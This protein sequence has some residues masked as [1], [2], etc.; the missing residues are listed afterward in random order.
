[1]HTRSKVLG[2]A[3]ECGFEIRLPR[4]GSYEALYTPMN[5]EVVDFAYRP[6]SSLALYGLAVSV[7]RERNSFPF[8]L[9][10]PFGAAKS[11]KTV[12]ARFKSHFK[13]TKDHFAS[14]AAAPSIHFDVTTDAENPRFRLHLPPRSS[15]YSTYPGFWYLLGF[16]EPFKKQDVKIAGRGATGFEVYG[17]FND[18]GDVALNKQGSIFF[19]QVKFEDLLAG[20]PANQAAAPAEVLIQAEIQKKSVKKIV[21][22][23][24]SETDRLTVQKALT[25][26]MSSTLAACNVDASARFKIYQ[27]GADSLKIVTVPNAR[28]TDTAVEVFFNSDLST[29]LQWPKGQSLSFRLAEPLEQAFT[30][31]PQ[32]L[33]GF[34]GKYPVTVLMNGFGEARHWIAGRGYCSVLAVLRENMPP[35]TMPVLFETDQYNLRLE[36]IDYATDTITFPLGEG[37]MDMKMQFTSL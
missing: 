9:M 12:D 31:A 29:V 5:G 8:T 20:L 3:K 36:F 19:P 23:T 27:V 34:K 2:G 37:E 4:F 15:L 6:K 30:V 24:P 11:P 32:Q 14:S 22:A 25:E 28:A 17:F 33:D 21:V 26:L 13:D 35:L 18:N 10:D 1:M 7:T 16:E